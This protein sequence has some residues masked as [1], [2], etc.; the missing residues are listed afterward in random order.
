[1]TCQSSET[2]VNW[3]RHGQE[4]IPFLLPDGHVTFVPVLGEA[5]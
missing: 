1:M 5:R 3:C 4:V 2:Y